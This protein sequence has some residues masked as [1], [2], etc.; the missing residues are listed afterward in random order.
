MPVLSFFR[1]CQSP[2]EEKMS[3]VQFKIFYG[4]NFKRCKMHRMKKERFE[5]IAYQ[6]LACEVFKTVRAF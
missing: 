2:E 1:L 3:S 6:E 4:D 5:Q